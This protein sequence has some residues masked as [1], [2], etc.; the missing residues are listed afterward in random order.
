MP[1]FALA[2]IASVLLMFALMS[3][4]L[5]LY[6]RQSGASGYILNNPGCWVNILIYPSSSCFAC[7]FTVNNTRPTGFTLDP[8]TMY[9]TSSVLFCLYPS[10]PLLGDLTYNCQYNL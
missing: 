9:T 8:T 2:L 5:A 4:Q 10:I 7:P 6:P 1:P 3:V